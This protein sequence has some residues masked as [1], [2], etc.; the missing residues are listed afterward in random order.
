MVMKIIKQGPFR[1]LI[2]ANDNCF[3]ILNERNVLMCFKWLEDEKKW[4]DLVLARYYG[5][6]RS[7]ADIHIY[8]EDVYLMLKTGTVFRLDRKGRNFEPLS[9]LITIEQYRLMQYTM[10]LRANKIELSIPNVCDLKI[11]PYTV[12]NGVLFHKFSAIVGVPSDK[13]FKINQ[14]MNSVIMEYPDLSCA[15]QHGDVL[16]LGFKDGKI[17]IG[18]AKNLTNGG[19]PEVREYIQHYHNYLDDNPEIVCI[20][21]HEVKESHRVFV[22]TRF[23]IY[24]L[25][26]RYPEHIR[27]GL[28]MCKS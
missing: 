28:G 23:H 6:T 21:V 13:E 27:Y 10:L 8:E 15:T 17:E 12:G 18:L 7:I 5:C 16:L 11:P 9:H 26:I 20:E 1:R 22:A 25:I 19:K 4:K 2:V 24:E 14:D 3:Y